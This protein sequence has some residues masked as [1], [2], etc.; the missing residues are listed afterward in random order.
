MR[1]VTNYLIY[2]SIFFLSSLC[3]TLCGSKLSGQ[4]YQNYDAFLTNGSSASINYAPGGNVHGVVQVWTKSKPSTVS[5]VL[6][7]DPWGLTNA[8]ASG[9]IGMIYD[10]NGTAQWS[11]GLTNLNTTQVIAFPFMGFG[12]DVWGYQNGNQG[13]TFPVLV[14]N[15]FSLTTEVQYSLT[16]Q[17][18]TNMDV[19]FDLWLAP[20]ANY[21]LGSTGAVEVEILPYCKYRGY[22]DAYV[23][24][25][26]LPCILNGQQTNFSFLEYDAVREGSGG[27][28]GAG[29]TI[30]FYPN[31]TGLASGDLQFDAAVLIKEAA[32][33]AAVGTWYL[34]GYNMGTEFGIGSSA[35][36]VFTLNRF[37][38]TET[39]PP[40][41]LSAPQMT[42]SKTN[43]D[44]LLSGPAGSNY[45]L[46]VSTNLLSWTP[47]ITST[48][49]V[50]GTINL[51]NAL[52]GYKQS[53]YRTVIP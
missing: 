6:G 38:L 5:W 48:I 33:T 30:L 49:P 31:G 3:L 46:Q 41:S 43:F 15:L 22:W 52:N 14:S 10:G 50:S 7:P 26:S 23:K 45:V 37:R 21:N 47:V 35:N 8:N 18:S 44:F 40:L 29:T 32:A 24:T 2:E 12:N 27:G 53:F 1:L 39:L 34:P 13:L 51:T 17:T 42:A 25:I 16:G 11:V 4:T 19:L 36:F 28:K 9:Q 20:S